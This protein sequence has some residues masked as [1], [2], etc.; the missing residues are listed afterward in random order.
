M[1]NEHDQALQLIAI[2]H[3]LR[4]RALGRSL[5]FYGTLQGTLRELL[6]LVVPFGSFDGL[7]ASW[8]RASS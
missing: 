2:S 7:D 8:V 5:G 6:S 4:K 3:H 1:A